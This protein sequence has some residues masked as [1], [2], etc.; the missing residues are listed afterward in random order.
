MRIIWQTVRRFTNEIG[1]LRVDDHN[2]NSH[3][4]CSPVMWTS[5]TQVQN[6]GMHILVISLFHIFQ[7]SISHSGIAIDSNQNRLYDAQSA[8]K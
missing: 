5:S 4:D 7:E 3:A 8:G 2:I 6:K 1:S